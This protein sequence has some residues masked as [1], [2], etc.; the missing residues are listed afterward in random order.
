MI[1]YLSSK[2]VK[3]EDLYIE[4]NNLIDTL[5]DNINNKKQKHYMNNNNYNILLNKYNKYNEISNK[6]IVLEKEQIIYN[7]IINLTG[8]KGIPRKIINIKLSYVEDEINNIIYPFLNKKIIISKDINDINVYFDDIK[9]KT[10]FGG[11]CESFLLSIAFK[12]TLSKFFNIPQCGLLIIDEGV[13]VFDNDN[14]EKF[15]IISDFIKKYYNH[16]ILI[17]HI[18]SFND[19]ISQFMKINKNKDKTSHILF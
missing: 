11:G 3:I 16:I 9:N 5:T 4:L 18:N 13:S 17:T 14:V 2:H 7:N 19:Y 1:I 15:Y 6:I 12:I 8:I 10:N